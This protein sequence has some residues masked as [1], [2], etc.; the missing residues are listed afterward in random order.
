VSLNENVD[1]YTLVHSAYTQ[2]KRRY[3]HTST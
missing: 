3:L 1:I 2:W